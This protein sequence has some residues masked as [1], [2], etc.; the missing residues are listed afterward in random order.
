MPDV[1][2]LSHRVAFLGA[3][4]LLL[5]LKLS[6]KRDSVGCIAAACGLLGAVLRSRMLVLVYALHMVLSF[7]NGLLHGVSLLVSSGKPDAGSGSPTTVPPVEASVSVSSVVAF[8]AVELL[9]CYVAATVC[10]LCLALPQRPQSASHPSRSPAPPLRPFTLPS[11]AVP[12]WLHEEKPRPDLVRRRQ[13]AEE[14]VARAQALLL[15]F[16]REEEELS[17]DRPRTPD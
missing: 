9:H 11:P 4:D 2:S 13:Q 6:R 1:A 10:R 16:E 14:A 15:E 8:T 12:R 17:R 5:G 7:T 3:L